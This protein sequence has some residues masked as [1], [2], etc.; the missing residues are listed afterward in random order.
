M[1]GFKTTRTQTTRVTP[2][3]VRENPPGQGRHPGS[4]APVK[5]RA[6]KRNKRKG[7]A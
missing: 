5:K 4:K 3:T 2:E 7:S 1:K 6:E